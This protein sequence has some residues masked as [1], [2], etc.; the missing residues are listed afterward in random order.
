[1]PGQTTI[2]SAATV[3][4]QGI[5][6]EAGRWSVPIIRDVVV[7]LTLKVAGMVELNGSLVGTEQFTPIGAPVQLKEAVPEIPAP[8]MERVKEAAW[9]AA[10]VTESEAPGARLRPKSGLPVE[11]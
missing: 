11:V 3:H 4:N 2:P 9:P 10:T 6:V 1:M 5:G 7:T 8:P